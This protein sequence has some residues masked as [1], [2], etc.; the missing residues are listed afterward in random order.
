MAIV[1]PGPRCIVATWVDSFGLYGSVITTSH[2]RILLTL[3]LLMD[4]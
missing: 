4:L 3:I 1:S 2:P